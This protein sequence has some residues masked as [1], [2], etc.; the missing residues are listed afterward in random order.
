MSQLL[1]RIEER[2]R[3]ETD[4]HQRAELKA[5]VAGYMARL[6]RFQE[7]KD[8]IAEVRQI[9]GDG[10]SG[11]VTALLMIAEALT[12]Y[13]ERLASGASDRVAR[14]L[15][16]AHAMKD[17]EV[18]SLAS[19]WKA[20]LD[21]ED[22]KFESA[23]RSI[24]VSLAHVEETNH[25]SWTR[26]SIVLALGFSLCGDASS[27]Q[28]WFLKGRH[29]ALEEGDQV[30]LDA[31]LHNKAVFGLA[32]LRAQRCKGLENPQQTARARLELS[33]TRNLQALA[34]VSAHGNYVDLADARL[35]M[36]EQQFEKALDAL[37]RVA[38]FG[39]FPTGH[40]NR[41][42]LALERAFCLAKLGRHS[43]AEA[44]MTL[45]DEKELTSLDV[46]D[47]LVSAW[48]KYEL[49]SL[50][51]QF[52]NGQACKTS[53]E[54]AIAEQDQLIVRLKSLLEPFART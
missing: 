3:T 37:A 43:D 8:V 10:R 29:H 50:G 33:S 11:R 53:L 34:G 35:L 26:N 54:G 42:L 24:G 48:M 46:D 52:G 13:Y 39:P 20:F 47:R 21:F 18:V 38:G 51:P 28:H 17:Q 7:A 41:S 31:L 9:F 12:M 2:L 6:G 23:F 5:K 49:A 14:A 1:I 30:S 45:Y 15:L 4:A 40:F 36:L 19:A 22:S 27:S 16:L 32:W 44:A 25:A